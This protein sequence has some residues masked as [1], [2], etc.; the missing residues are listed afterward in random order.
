MELF[1]ASLEPAAVPELQLGCRTS[2]KLAHLIP[3]RS[4]V[5]RHKYDIVDY[6]YRPT[7]QSISKILDS[8]YSFEF[9][10]NL[11]HNGFGRYRFALV[12]E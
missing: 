6:C 11:L 2:V 1:S 10:Y 9:Q 5:H 8:C 7:I 4:N 12:L 3:N